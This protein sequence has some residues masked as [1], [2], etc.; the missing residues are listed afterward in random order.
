MSSKGQ[1]SVPFREVLTTLEAN[2][3]RLMKIVGKFRYFSRPPSTSGTKRLP[4]IGFPVSGKRVKIAYV[5]RID[6]IIQGEDG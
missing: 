2:G 4:K 1:S 3:Y 6:K 5:K